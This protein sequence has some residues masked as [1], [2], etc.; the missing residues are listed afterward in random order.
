M[1]LILIVLKLLDTFSPPTD[2]SVGGSIIMAF[3]CV[4]DM[5]WKRQ[6]IAIVRL[7]KFN[8]TLFVFLKKTYTSF[9]NNVAGVVVSH[10]HYF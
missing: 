5:A 6:S 2:V 9:D 10:S 7:S 3:C 4:S 8:M 1:T